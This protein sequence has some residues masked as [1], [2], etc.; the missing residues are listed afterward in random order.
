M[1][2][3]RILDLLAEH[4]PLSAAEI[5]KLAP[6]PR[7]LARSQCHFLLQKLPTTQRRIHVAGWCLDAPGLRAY[8]R[9]VYD[10]GDKPDK[11]R[12][13]VPVQEAQRQRYHHRMARTLT[14]VFDLGL[15][16]RQRRVGVR[17]ISADTQPQPEQPT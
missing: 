3:Q 16:T 9:P 17:A 12:P 4:G 2:R 13:T 7:N 6:M 8:P 11:P 1:S 14:S 10:L 5:S 15:S